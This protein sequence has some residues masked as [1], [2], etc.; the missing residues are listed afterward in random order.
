MAWAPA[1]QSLVLWDRPRDAQPLLVNSLITNSY[2]KPRGKVVPFD[3]KQRDNP[4]SQVKGINT[5]VSSI[6]KAS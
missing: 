1:L 6:M 5:V 4:D 2:A 3:T